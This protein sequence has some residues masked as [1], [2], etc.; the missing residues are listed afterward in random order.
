[1]F[2]RSLLIVLVL[3]LTAGGYLYEK[4]ARERGDVGPVARLIDFAKFGKVSEVF[5]PSSSRKVLQYNSRASLVM[6][7]E[8]HKLLEN[9]RA[10]LVLNRREL[11]S[12][13]AA[14]NDQIVDE[15]LVYAHRIDEDREHYLERFPEIKEIGD[16]II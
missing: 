15:A 14:I 13:L 2:D 8:K 1:M 9:Q 5:K 12:Q 7:Q 11:L 16:N 6:L 10:Q 4:Y 3:F